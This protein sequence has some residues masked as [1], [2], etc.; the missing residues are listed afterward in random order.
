M[1]DL[2]IFKIYK[3]VFKAYMI[4]LFYTTSSAS[5]IHFVIIIVVI[6]KNYLNARISVM[7]IKSFITNV[8]V[9][10]NCQY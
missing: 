6:M 10:L 3:T 5:N 4:P 9:I 1:N 8:N 7:N 2:T